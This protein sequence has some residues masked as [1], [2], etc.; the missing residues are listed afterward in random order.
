M[1]T[2]TESQTQSR[3]GVS[4]EHIERMNK[5][6]DSLEL[7]DVSMY[8]TPREV[9]LQRIADSVAAGEKQW[10]PSKEIR[11]QIEDD[12]AAADAAAGIVR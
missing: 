7:P 10:E 9:R 4:R 2:S 1:S 5:F 12:L 11:R 6:I 3:Y 8:I